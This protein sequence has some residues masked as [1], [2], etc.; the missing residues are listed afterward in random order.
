MKK[1]VRFNVAIQWCFNFQKQV[2]IPQIN[3]IKKKYNITSNVALENKGKMKFGVICIPIR[4]SETWYLC[5]AMHKINF[6][7]D[8]RSTCE[9]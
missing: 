7:M 4:K 9:K 6:K 8:Y 2:V 1:Q 5:H 3:I